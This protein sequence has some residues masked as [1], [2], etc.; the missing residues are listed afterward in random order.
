MWFITL[1]H[2]TAQTFVITSKLSVTIYS[3]QYKEAKGLP[4][5]K[6]NMLSIVLDF[7]PYKCNSRGLCNYYN[8]IL[9][10]CMH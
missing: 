7:Y 6:S 5:N 8:S 9:Q 3:I 4:L 10:R 2:Q 1:C